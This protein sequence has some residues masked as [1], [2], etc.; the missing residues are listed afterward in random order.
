MRG[1]SIVSDICG[2]WKPPTLQ[3]RVPTKEK[4]GW[5]LESSLNDSLREPPHM[6]LVCILINPVLFQSVLEDVEHSGIYLLKAKG[7]RMRNLN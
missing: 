3:Q 7:I 1:E 2:R 6:R 4:D 5:M